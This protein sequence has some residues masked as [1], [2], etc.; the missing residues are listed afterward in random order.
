MVNI[1]ITGGAGYIGSI[2]TH[3][4]ISKGHNII[5]YDN[6]SKG[7]KWAIPKGVKFIQGSLSE[8]EKLKKTFNKNNIEAVI[9]FAA[10]TEV[11]KSVIDPYSFYQNNIVETLSLLQVMKEVCVNHIV[12]S[13][14]CAIFGEPK[15]PLLSETHPKN[16]ISPYGFTKLVIEQMLSDGD[17]AYG[18]KSCSLRYFNASGAAYGIGEAHEPETHLIPIILDAAFGKRKNIKIFGAD[19]PT[20]DGTCVRDYIHV[21]DLARAHEVALRKIIKENKSLQYNLGT[22]IGKS[23]L[24]IIELAREITGKKIEVILE[25]R[26]PGDPPKLVAD[27]K[28][29]RHELK[30]KTEK[31]IKEIIESAWE[32]HQKYYSQESLDL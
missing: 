9:H 28:K 30:F 23:V 5:V 26:R 24:E 29:I 3:Y 31:T 14:T 32:W 18:L 22:G 11:G 25:K 10:S 21:L 4:L 16:P 27:S 6:L 1:L 20:H 12:F 2:T 17:L 8:K 15:T 13:S 7:H 19:Y